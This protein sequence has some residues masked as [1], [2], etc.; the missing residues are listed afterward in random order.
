M[1]VCHVFLQDRLVYIFLSEYEQK[2]NNQTYSFSAISAVSR[3]SQLPST[4]ITIPL[5]PASLPAQTEV[6]WLSLREGEMFNCSHISP[7]LTSNDS[8][9]PSLQNSVPWDPSAPP[10]ND[11]SDTS[12]NQE[13]IKCSVSTSVFEKQEW[14]KGW[15]MEAMPQVPTGMFK[16]W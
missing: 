1:L 16:L 8:S 13:W 12:G 3:I 9:L 10:L 4:A 5:I 15:R 11:T 2:G 6:L 14:V 7:S